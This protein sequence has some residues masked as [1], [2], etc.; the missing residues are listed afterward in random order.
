MGGG[1]CDWKM[2][3]AGSRLC[4]CWFLPSMRKG[5]KKA[6]KGHIT[7][8]SAAPRGQR[9]LGK[10]AHTPPGAEEAPVSRGQDSGG[11]KAREPPTEPCRRPQPMVSAPPHVSFSPSFLFSAGPGMPPQAERQARVSPEGAC[12]RGPTG[13]SDTQPPASGAKRPALLLRPQKPHLH[14]GP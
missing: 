8:E 11:R 2:A 13:S 9:R 5:R 14:E 10:E 12:T 1:L 3:G 6:V 4:P 7:G